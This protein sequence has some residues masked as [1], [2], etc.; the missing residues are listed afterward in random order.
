[1]QIVIP[2]AGRGD[3]F[4]RA[5]YTN[6]K[7]LIE[8][9]GAPIIQHVINLFPGETDFVFICAQDHLDNTPLAK[10]LERAAPKG[11]IV[12]IAPHKKGPV[13]SALE[14]AR[15]I[16]D[17]EPTIL[18]YCDFSVYWNYEHFKATMSERGCAG[19]ITA[20]RGFHPHSLGPN[21]YG[22]MREKDNYLLEIREKQSFTDN[23]MDEYAS[24]GTYYFRSGEMMKQYFGAAMAA[25]LAVRGECYASLPFNLMVADGLD[26]FIYELERFLQW[27]TPEDLEEYQSWSNYF[28]ARKN[29]SVNRVPGTNLIP[30]AGAGVRF[31]REGYIEPK[32]LVDV[33]GLPM[34]QRAMESLPQSEKWVAVCQSEHVKYSKLE[35][36][37]RGDG[38]DLRIILV[39][40]LTEGQA[41]T[42]LLAKDVLDMN[43][44]LLIAPCDAATIHDSGRLSDM[45][46]SSSS[47]CLVWTFRNHPHANRNPKQYGW[48]KV[49]PDGKISGISCKIPLGADVRNDPGIIGM[50]WFREARIFV[51]AAEKLIQE[52]RRVN[53]EFYVDSAVEAVVELG[54]SARVFDVTSYVGLGNPDDVRT[55][56]YWASYFRKTRP[57]YF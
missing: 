21:F 2:M 26:V 20:Y 6:I 13:H 27:G 43:A 34:I 7:P 52:N 9:D 41:S 46:N 11:K 39:D 3:R 24:A 54:Y 48:V 8:V 23:K 38:R 17:D 22:Y 33:D 42:C 35:E 49:G 28:A 18:N 56:N 36:T 1:M 14:A 15:Y 32:P 40:K 19:C 57:E 29:S 50:F 53:N 51:E 12:P 37:L 10:V 55:Y 25:N 5:G 31:Q 4:I 45:M 47:D 16:D 30:M 44:P